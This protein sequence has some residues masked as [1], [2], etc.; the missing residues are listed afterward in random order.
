[1]NHQGLLW[2]VHCVATVVLRKQ[3]NYKRVVIRSKRS[4]CFKLYSYSL[5]DIQYDLEEAANV[6]AKLVKMYESVDIIR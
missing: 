6:R 1:M 3:L 2:N 5:G 4:S